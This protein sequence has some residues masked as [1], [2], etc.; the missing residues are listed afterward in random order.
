MLGMRA[1]VLIR[2][3]GH[4]ITIC[5]FLTPLGLLLFDPDRSDAREHSFQIVAFYFIII[6]FWLFG[7]KR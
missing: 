7:R 5:A 4:I 1:K 6:G 2:A 3:A